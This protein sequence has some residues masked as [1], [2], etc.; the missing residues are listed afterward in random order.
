MAR[1]CTSGFPSAEIGKDGFF[2]RVCFNLKFAFVV[3][4]II[5]YSFQRVCGSWAFFSVHYDVG[6]VSQKA[7]I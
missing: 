3:M 1:V 5:R 2:C 4:P 6:P 7:N